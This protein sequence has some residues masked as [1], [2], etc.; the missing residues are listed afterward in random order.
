MSYMPKYMI[1]LIRICATRK[2]SLYLQTVK[3]IFYCLE[4]ELLYD[5]NVTN[6][7]LNYYFCHGFNMQNKTNFIKCCGIYI[8]TFSLAKNAAVA[9]ITE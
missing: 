3:G 9:W 8:T 6:S 5:N 7:P 4:E 1:G 2:V